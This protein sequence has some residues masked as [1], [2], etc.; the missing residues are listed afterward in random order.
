MI[1]R[2]SL[3]FIYDSKLTLKY[4]ETDVVIVIGVFSNPMKRLTTH[5]L[6][7]N[8]Q[9][10]FISFLSSVD[11]EGI[12]TDVNGLL[13]ENQEIVKQRLIQTIHQSL[14]PSDSEFMKAFNDFLGL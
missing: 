6:K 1:R 3:H 9:E 11:G 2:G 12:Y 13:L 4:K 8:T 10:F 5:I 14:T 7:N